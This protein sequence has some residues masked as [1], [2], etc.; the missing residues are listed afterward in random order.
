MLAIEPIPAFVDNY[1][2]CV[3]NGVDACV[4][5]PGDATPA[6]EFLEAHKLKLRAILITHHHPDHI[7]GIATLRD[8]YALDTVYG[9]DNPRIS[10]IT[11]VVREGDEI[12]VLGERFRVLE[13]PGHTLDHIAYASTEMQPPALFC[14]DTLFAAGCG[15]L[16]EGTPAQMFNS[17][18]KFKKLPPETR[19]FCTHEYTQANLRFARAVE[20]DNLAL[21]Q[22]AQSADN[23]RANHQPTLPSTLALELETNPFLRTWQPGVQNAALQHGSQSTDEADIFAAIRRWKD[24]F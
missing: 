20:P 10:G 11:Q 19:I 22:R 14:G 2:W 16:F 15:R 18:N 8:L 1:I 3:H 23:V 4:V 6:I 9:P 17:L 24:Q 13:V 21:K 12:E 7:G 5:D